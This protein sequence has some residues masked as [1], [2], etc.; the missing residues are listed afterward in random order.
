MTHATGFNLRHSIP[1]PAGFIRYWQTSR[2][3]SARQT[4]WSSA[5]GAYSGERHATMHS[6]RASNVGLEAQLDWQA[7]ASSNVQPGPKI[8]HSLPT[9]SLAR[10]RSRLLE[11]GDQRA[12]R[13]AEV[14]RRVAAL[15]IRALGRG[16][17]RTQGQVGEVRRG[18]QVGRKH[19]VAAAGGEKKHDE[20]AGTHA[21]A[22]Q[23]TLYKRFAAD[24]NG[25][26]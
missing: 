5:S 18:D 12:R 23:P 10:L 22:R 3:W 17:A 15:S 14:R 1:R 19:L 2:Q 20:E 4:V 26:F 13:Q 11:A 6:Q 24:G 9:P 7:L 25:H 8:V 21:R 16:H